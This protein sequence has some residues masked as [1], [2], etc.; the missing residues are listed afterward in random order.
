LIN[1]LT[2]AT[3]AIQEREQTA[4]DDYSGKI[5][6]KVKLTD[7]TTC[8]VIVSDNGVGIPEDVAESIFAPYVTTKEQGKGFGIGLSKSLGIA[9]EHDGNLYYIDSDPPGATFVLE[10]PI[11]ATDDQS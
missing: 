2:N 9:R 6:V 5:T 7:D 4:P 3:H 10:L 11:H 1:L 8:Q